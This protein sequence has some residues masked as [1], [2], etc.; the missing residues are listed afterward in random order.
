MQFIVSVMF[1]EV[2]TQFQ[3]NEID[4]YILQDQGRS[5]R[6]YCTKQAMVFESEIK[7]F[8]VVLKS[9]TGKVLHGAST[10][11]GVASLALRM[12]DKHRMRQSDQRV[13]WLDVIGLQ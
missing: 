7:R 12:I 3:E 11:V 8:D 6:I 9:E 10:P 4:V 13:Y 1:D 2:F 5:V